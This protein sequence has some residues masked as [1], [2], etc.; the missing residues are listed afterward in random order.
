MKYAH[1]RLE[2][3]T[4]FWLNDLNVRGP[5]GRPRRRWENNQEI[6]CEDVNWIHVVQDRHRCHSSRKQGN[7]PPGSMK[8]EDFLTS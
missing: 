2:M 6:A 1:G 4:T 8:V 5:L 3:F 7:K